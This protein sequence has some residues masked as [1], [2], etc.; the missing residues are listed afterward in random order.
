MDTLVQDLRY[1]VRMLAKAPGFT[2]IAVLTLALGVG[3][4]S[5]MF[6]VMEGVV[7]APLRAVVKALSGPAAISPF[8]E[9]IYIVD[10]SRAICHNVYTR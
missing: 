9:R 8:G 5:A 3:A 4:N 2:A 10:T 6:S 1:S 7:F